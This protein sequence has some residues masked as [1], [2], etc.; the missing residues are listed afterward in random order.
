MVRPNQLLRPPPAGVVS[1]R[2]QWGQHP[3]QVGRIHFVRYQCGPRPRSGAA[4][5]FTT[6]VQADRTTGSRPSLKIQKRPSVSYGYDTSA[7]IRPRITMPIRPRVRNTYDAN[8]GKTTMAEKFVTMKLRPRQ[9]PAFNANT[10]FLR[11]ETLHSPELPRRPARGKWP[12]ENTFPRP[13]RRLRSVKAIVNCETTGN[14]FPSSPGLPTERTESETVPA[15]SI[16]KIVRPNK[17]PSSSIRQLA[18]SSSHR[19]LE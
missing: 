4:A 17:I 1:L 11:G 7:V 3:G 9:E 15:P 16:G 18:G 5:C 14:S 6:A 19:W 12:S 10:V 2:R 13:S 8:L